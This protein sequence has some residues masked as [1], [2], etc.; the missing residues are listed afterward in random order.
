ML[1]VAGQQRSSPG[2][3]LVRL[4]DTYRACSVFTSSALDTYTEYESTSFTHTCIF[5]LSSL[6]FFFLVLFWLFFFLCF[7]FSLS[8]FFFFFPSQFAFSFVS[9]VSLLAFCFS[10]NVSGLLLACVIPCCA[11]HCTNNV[12]VLSARGHPAHP[13]S[14]LILHPRDTQ[15][16]WSHRGVENAMLCHRT[17]YDR[18]NIHTHASNSGTLKERIRK[19]STLLIALHSSVVLPSISFF[20]SF[21]FYNHFYFPAQLVGGF[22]PQ[23]SSGQ[24]VATGVVPSPPRYV[25]SEFYRA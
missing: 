6:F 23:R 5:A 22:S 4:V 18:L 15:A 20:F 19:K 17:G 13:V 24:V 14:S 12:C 10:F 25:P 3:M 16:L 1:D 8:F 2:V 21:F 11:F 7:F 9:F